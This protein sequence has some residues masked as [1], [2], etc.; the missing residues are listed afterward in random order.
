MNEL[1][2]SGCET[3]QTLLKRIK[4][5]FISIN[6]ERKG[7]YT[8]QKCNTIHVLIDKKEEPPKRKTHKQLK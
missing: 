2:K 6:K 4:G 8:C 5:K 7:V 1:Q 3:C